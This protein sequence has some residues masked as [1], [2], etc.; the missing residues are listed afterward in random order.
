MNLQRTLFNKCNK[1][2]IDYLVPTH[3]LYTYK[4]NFVV[5]TYVRS[6]E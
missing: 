2:S 1:V 6:F 5:G 4:V 3:I